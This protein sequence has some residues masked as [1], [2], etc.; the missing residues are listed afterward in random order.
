MRSP[1][2]AGDIW[3]PQVGDIR[4]GDTLSGWG[5]LGG[6]RVGDSWAEDIWGHQSWGHLGT[7]ELGATELGSPCWV[8]AFGDVRIEVPLP[9]WGHLGPPGW[10][11]QSWGLLDWLR[12]LGP[13]GWGHLGT[14][15]MGTPAL[16]HSGTP[17]L[18]TPC[19]VGTFGDIGVGVTLLGW[20]VWDPRVGDIWGH[21]SWGRPVWLGTFG[22]HRLG[23][24][25]LGST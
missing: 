12:H 21:W 23:P 19:R 4:D 13:L 10:G 11:H 22:T 20:G 15:Q 14:S 18:G 24:S 17:V 9:G 25:E 1:C 3:D 7:F 5:H 6:S 16:G 8:G 2:L